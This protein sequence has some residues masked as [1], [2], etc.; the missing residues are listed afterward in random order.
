MS[1]LGVDLPDPSG[2]ITQEPCAGRQE[3]LFPGSLAAFAGSVTCAQAQDALFEKQ[4][5][6]RLSA[7]DE[8]EELPCAPKRRPAPEHQW[9]AAGLSTGER[10][11]RRAP[12][13]RRGRQR[14]RR[15][16]RGLARRA[17]DRA[18]RGHA[19]GAEGGSR[20]SMELGGAAGGC[21]D[22]D[23]CRA[24][25]PGR[26][27]RGCAPGHGG[28]DA[29][30]EVR[31]TEASVDEARAVVGILGGVSKDSGGGDGDDGLGQHAPAHGAV[32]A[33]GH[34]S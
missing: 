17:S 14:P 34:R 9:R 4:T 18:P 6:M 2:P 10:P 27:C 1:H 12:D 23:A 31:K 29:T 26:A 30:L 16:P 25:E 8:T 28:G 11:P 19:K 13:G 33:G 3:P 22:G 32:A 24:T 15:M 5:W 20:P 7:G 21:R